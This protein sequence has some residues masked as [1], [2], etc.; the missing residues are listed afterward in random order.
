MYPLY[1]RKHATRKIIYA[2]IHGTIDLK[3]HYVCI[4]IVPTIVPDDKYPQ[5]NTGQ[6]EAG[7]T[8]HAAGRQKVD[9]NSPHL[10]GDTSQGCQ[11][12]SRGIL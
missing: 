3:A 8:I 7:V 9:P 1:A 10:S 11:M 12:G 5:N 4:I 6:F 2:K